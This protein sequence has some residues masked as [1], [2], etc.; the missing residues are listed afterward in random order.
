[1]ARIQ[2]LFLFILLSA[3][4]LNA[5]TTTT[6]YRAETFGSLASGDYTPFW[7]LNQ[8]WGMKSV[9]ANNFYLR[10]G[11][12]HQQQLNEDWSFDAGLDLAGGDPASSDYA[13]IQQLYGRLNWKFLRL[14]LG[15]R[16][17]YHSLLNPRLSSGD[18]IF[19]NNARPIP[20]VK[21]SIPEFIL[22][23]YTRGNVFVKAHFSVGKY[24]D[25]SWVEERA[26]PARY[27]YATDVLSHHKS[28]YFRIGD[29]QRHNKQFVVG[30][31]H[32]TQWG[33]TFHKYRT[34]D[35]LPHWEQFK[36]P[37]GLDDFMRIVVAKEGSGRSSETDQ[38]HVAGS[39][40]GAYFLKYDHRIKGQKTVSAYLQHFFEDGSGMGFQNY[41]DNLIGLEYRSDTKDLLSGVVFEYVYTKNQTGPIH[42]NNDM[43]EEHQYLYK[44]GNGDDNYYNHAEY[45]H[46][47]SYFGKSLGTPLFL[48]PE[49]NTDGSVNFHSTRIIALHLALNGYLLPDLQYRLLLTHGQSWGR[50]RLP[51]TEVKKGLGS[52]LEFSYAFPKWKETQI[53]LALGY[54]D[55]SFFCGNSFGAGLTLS[56][57]GLIYAK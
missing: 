55:G 31:Q 8:S 22:I 53:T 29:I 50:Y 10:A 7:M 4:G 6:T 20:E 19:S 16:E 49:Y 17:D 2:I 5:Q 1:M 18:F 15:L 33:G 26:M 54:D 11:V 21:V 25:S 39:Q 3:I 36:Q 56:K 23:P 30:L 14:D 34:V 57:R 48:S 37:T 27:D 28:V 9:V 47:V 52:L 32:N 38:V 12:F 35:G 43:E 41:R 24:L 40:W 51:Y 44:K 46:G 42:F 45:T 13:W